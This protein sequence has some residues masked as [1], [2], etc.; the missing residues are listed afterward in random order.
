MPK[1]DFEC[2]VLREMRIVMRENSEKIDEKTV[3]E[4]ILWEDFEKFYNSLE[5]FDYPH[6]D[7]LLEFV[8]YF[9]LDSIHSK[10]EIYINY[11]AFR[12]HVIIKKLIGPSSDK[13]RNESG[14]KS[15]RMSGESV[16]SYT[17]SN[18]DT[19][20]RRYGALSG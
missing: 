5:N 9:F 13:S 14:L 10:D 19:I 4:L 15:R 8:K 16:G 2:Q 12:D 20:K 1:S 7:K 18:E 6:R 11:K 3:D 17:G